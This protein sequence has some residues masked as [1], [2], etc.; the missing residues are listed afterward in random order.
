MP[1]RRLLPL[2][3]L[4]LALVLAAC[5]DS[6][7]TGKEAQATATSTPAAAATS[8]PAANSDTG[9]QAAKPSGAK[10][11][12]PSKPTAK[13]DPRKTYVATVDTSCGAFQI[14]LAVKQAPK[15]AASFDSLVKQ[16]FYDGLTFHRIVPG[17]VIQGGDPAGNGT[18]GPGYSVTEA[19][20]SK[21]SYSHGTVA[22]A[23][24]GAEAPGTS[25]SQF[26][27]VTAPDAGL[28]PDYALLGKVT[29]GLDVVDAIGVVP[30]RSDEQPVDP[31][32]IKSIK[33]SAK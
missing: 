14:T 1:A 17:F 32:V 9:C 19:P 27:V 29:K 24:S 7:S 25:G 31:V 16:G 33:V 20:P 11:P 12:K 3:L 21:V 26:F 5:G 10:K 4:L 30:T 8:T 6:S 23:K 28:P 15:T 18:G 13:L 22:M 2:A